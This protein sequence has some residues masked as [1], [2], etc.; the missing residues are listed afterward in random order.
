[1]PISWW[2]ILSVPPHAV[3]LDRQLLTHQ[4]LLVSCLCLRPLWLLQLLALPLGQVGSAPVLNVP[5]ATLD[6]DR[7]GVGG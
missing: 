2:L 6:H 5:G 1:M 4:W 3:H 7:M